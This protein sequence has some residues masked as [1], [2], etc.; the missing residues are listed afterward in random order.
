MA[1]R[2]ICHA[3]S[4][5]FAAYEVTFTGDFINAERALSWGW[6]PE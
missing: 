1:G 3:S 6:C 5:C 2:G 4:V